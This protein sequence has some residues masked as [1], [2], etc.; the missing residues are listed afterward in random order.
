MQY[1]LEDKR[2]IGFFI[3]LLRSCISNKPYLDLLLNAQQG[4]LV[5]QN[6]EY[7]H[8]LDASRLVFL[9]QIKN[10]FFNSYSIGEVPK[11]SFEIEVLSI[12]KALKGLTKNIKKITFQIRLDK[13]QQ[14]T[15]P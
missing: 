14:L 9:V 7:F 6:G 11:I 10:S 1:V 2:K 12:F 5:M 13:N 15:Q 4:W 8:G 3:A